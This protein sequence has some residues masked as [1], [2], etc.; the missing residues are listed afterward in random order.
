MQSRNLQ[1]TI[2]H[3]NDVGGEGHV[4]LLLLVSREATRRGARGVMPRI[5]RRHRVLH[6]GAMSAGGSTGQPLV[7]MSMSTYIY[8]TQPA[9]N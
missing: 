6:A 8:L 4:L 5:E 3:S 2:Q 7:A 9:Y 1:P